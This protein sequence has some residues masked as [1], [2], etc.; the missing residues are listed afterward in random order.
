MYQKDVEILSPRKK[1]NDP[2]TRNRR[3]LPK[4]KRYQ[5]PMKNPR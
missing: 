2:K 4:S 5:T 1:E 3:Y